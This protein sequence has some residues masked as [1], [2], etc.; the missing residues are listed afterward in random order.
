MQDVANALYA[1]SQY[2]LMAIGLTLIYTVGRF[3]SFAH[4]AVYAIAAYVTF[5]VHRTLPLFPSAVLGV[6]AAVL[7][8]AAIEHIVFARIRRQSA[9]PLALLIASLGIFIVLQS[10]MALAFG[11]APRTIRSGVV[12]AGHLIL[13][14]RVTDVQL[15]GIVGGIVLCGTT[16]A[17][18]R[19]STIGR[20]LR[21]TASDSYLAKAVGV[22]TEQAMLL[23]TI[24]ASISGGFAGV[25]RAYDVDLRPGMGFAPLLMGVVAML[26]G[27][28]GRSGAAVFAAFAIASVQQIAVAFLPTHWQ[29]TVVFALLVFALVVRLR[30][31][32]TLSGVENVAVRRS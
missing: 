3:L 25:V 10:V 12:V 9:S 2:A 1:G 7:A 15:V 14:A 11:E 4:G 5:A 20:H 22:N 28:V 26:A 24:I 30:G 32:Q 13:G 8:G 16:W 18:V 17:F 23:A 19:W 21:A 29:D 31:S 27:G 6:A